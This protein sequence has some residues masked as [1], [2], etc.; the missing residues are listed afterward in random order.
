[1]ALPVQDGAGPVELGPFH[2]VDCPTSNL[3]ENVVAAGLLCSG[4]PVQSF[5]L[6]VGASEL[7][8]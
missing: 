7:P 2:V 3:I 6:H 5:P 8:S 4:R 1:M